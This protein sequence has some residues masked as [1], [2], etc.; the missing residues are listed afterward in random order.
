MTMT[1]EN[2]L[3]VEAV[4][5]EILTLTEIYDGEVITLHVD[6]RDVLQLA[7]YLYAARLD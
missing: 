5:G 3:T 4:S 6:V 7:S 2:G 1:L